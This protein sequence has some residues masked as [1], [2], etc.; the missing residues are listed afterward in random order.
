[1]KLEFSRQ[2]FEKY[3]NIKFHENPSSGSRIVSCGWT[4]MANLVVTFRSFANAPNESWKFMP[5]A[6][7]DP[8]TLAIERPQAYALDRT[9]TGIGCTEQVDVPNC[10]RQV[11]GFQFHP[12]RRP[13]LLRLFVVFQYFQACARILGHDR[14]FRMLCNS[15][16]SCHLVYR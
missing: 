8:A 6:G 3:S 2:I 5:S 15:S 1:M 4:D 9:A 7:L 16:L 14:H 10:D 11:P 12:G 13:F